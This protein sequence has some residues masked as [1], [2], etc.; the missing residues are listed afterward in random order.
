MALSRGWQVDPGILGN[1]VVL[2]ESWLPVL[3]Q[4]S[5]LWT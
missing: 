2:L 5:H 1:R 4:R 3:G